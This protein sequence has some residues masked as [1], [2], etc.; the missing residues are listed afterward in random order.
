VFSKQ[1][2]VLFCKSSMVEEHNLVEKKE[3]KEV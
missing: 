2:T 1:M 3:D